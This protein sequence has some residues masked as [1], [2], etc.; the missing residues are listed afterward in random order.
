M[1]TLQIL[2]QLREEHR[3]CGKVTEF[4]VD[5]EKCLVAYKGPGYSADVFIDRGSGDYD[6]SIVEHGIIGKWNDLH[7]GRDSGIP[8]S[9]LID[10]SAIIMILSA[11]TGLA[12]LFFLKRKRRS[13]FITAAIGAI[14]FAAFYFF[15][16]P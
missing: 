5:E 14:V 8:W 11:V 10:I 12:M 6:I 4:R 13:G 2:E 16:V 7:K 3:L 15:L 9:I 1:D